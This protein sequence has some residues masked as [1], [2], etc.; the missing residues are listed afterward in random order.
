MADETNPTE[1][2]PGPPGRRLEAPGAPTAGRTL[3]AP[4]GDRPVTPPGVTAPGPGG[5]APAPPLRTPAPSGFQQPADASWSS[6]RDF[7][8]TAAT[9]DTVPVNM[10]LQPKV[11]GQV[12]PAGGFA[13]PL[14]QVESERR[15]GVNGTVLA[16][17]DRDVHNPWWRHLLLVVAAG[18]LV[19]AVLVAGNAL[20][21]RL[22]DD[23][24]EPVPA[25]ETTVEAP[26][27]TAPGA[28]A[29]N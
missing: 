28:G 25:A 3:H 7:G 29:G 20:K 14:P 2:R 15:R 16:D 21:D 5:F 22:G 1:F 13:G 10:P 12:I 6:S 23:D 26:T 19:A 17:A 4:G 11:L 27:E 18:C 24:P 8:D 9:F